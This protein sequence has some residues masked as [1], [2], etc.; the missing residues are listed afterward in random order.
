[1]MEG[2]GSWM[3]MGM[4]VDH[5]ESGESVAIGESDDREEIGDI[6]D[7]GESVYSGDCGDSG[8]SGEMWICG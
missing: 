7:I 4:D 1:M 6:W 3:G 5:G 2:D 8:E